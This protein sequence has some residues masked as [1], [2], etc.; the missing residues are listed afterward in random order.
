MVLLTLLYACVVFLS[1]FLLFLVQPMVAKQLLPVLGGSAAVWTTCLVF[2]QSA[3]LLGYLYADRVATRLRPRTQAIVHVLLL[4]AALATLGLRVHPNAWAATWHP[5]ITVFVLLTLIA[6]LP[7]FALSA[8]T[9][10]LQAWYSGSFQAP[11][12]YRLFSLSN[13]GALLALVIYPVL[14]EP[15]FALKTQTRCW[16]AGF[17]LFAV[18]CGESPGVSAILCPGVK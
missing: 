18:L 5:F 12:P 17:F 13:V 10:L 16:S 4:T 2:F 8:T 3:L 6:G 14:V 1:A 9:P 7:Y 11:M 15:Y